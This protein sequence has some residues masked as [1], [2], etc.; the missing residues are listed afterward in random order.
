MAEPFVYR[1]NATIKD[2]D[3]RNCEVLN[4]RF[5]SQ[6]EPFSR[7]NEGS[8]IFNLGTNSNR[9]ENAWESIYGM[10]T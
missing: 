4:V 8:E 1:L 6:A 3:V 2:L 5:F 10:C 9:N 7:G